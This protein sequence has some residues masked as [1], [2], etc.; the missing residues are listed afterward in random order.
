MTK[1][2]SQPNT[3]M[4]DQLRSQQYASMNDQLRSQ[5]NFRAIAPCYR[6]KLSFNPSELLQ[7]QSEQKRA[8]CVLLGASQSS[9]PLSAAQQSFPTPT[10]GS[11]AH[12]ISVMREV[13]RLSS[14]VRAVQVGRDEV[15]A[16]E[17]ADTLLLRRGD[18]DQ[19]DVLV[20]LR[21]RTQHERRVALR[22]G[23]RRRRLQRRR[24]RASRARGRRAE[25]HRQSRLDAAV[26][27]GEAS[28]ANGA[29][30]ARVELRKRE[31]ARHARGCFAGNPL[32]RWPAL[33]FQRSSRECSN[34]T[35]R[36]RPLSLVSKQ[37][38]RGL[39][40]SWEE[41][42]AALGGDRIKCKPGPCLQHEGDAVSRSAIL[43]HRRRDGKAELALEPVLD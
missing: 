7:N 19:E 23:V 13:G 3:S 34:I 25:L 4:N 18:G 31:H 15:L 38:S 43:P 22:V 29:D 20:R 6:L 32:S 42:H 24:R 16:G 21:Q 12:P 30:A 14:V 1:L 17:G 39:Q 10:D 37:Y 8:G 36:S 5:H 33:R 40:A 27:K 26:A 35:V 28:R 11:N 2:R 41:L 9:T